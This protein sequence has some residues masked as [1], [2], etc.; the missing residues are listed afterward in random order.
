MATD[1]VRVMCQNAPHGL[2][3]HLGPDGVH[4]DER[5]ELQPGLNEGISADFM[6]RWLAAN[7]DSDLVLKGCIALAPEPA[8]EPTSAPEPAPE[9]A[10]AVEPTAEPAV[11]PAPASTEPPQE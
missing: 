6:D 3:L 9:P 7:A 2:V 10:P 4:T 11:A 8:P 5:V 1:R